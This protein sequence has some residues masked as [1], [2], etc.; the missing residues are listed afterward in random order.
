MLCLEESAVAVA[1]AA[2]AVSCCCSWAGADILACAG[3]RPI[4]GRL[5]KGSVTLRK[6]A[7][8]DGC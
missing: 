2:E 4:S 3:V 6:I 1:A 5:G 8:I 7:A